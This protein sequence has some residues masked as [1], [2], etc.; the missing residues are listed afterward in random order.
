MTLLRTFAVKKSFLPILLLVF[1][2]G[3][4]NLGG[5]FPG[6]DVINA[7]PTSTEEGFRDVLIIKDISTIPKSP[8]LPEQDILFSF[9]IENRD[10]DKKAENVIVDL[11]DA[12]LFKKKTKDTSGKEIFVLCN[13][14]KCLPDKCAGTVVSGTIPANPA[15]TI[16]PGDQKQINFVLKAPSKNE[17]ANLKSDIDLSF[18][19]RYNFAGS[20]LFKTVVVN[21]VEIKTRQRAG[22]AISLDI[23]EFFGSGP[24]KIDA[25]LKG[26]SYILS[27]YSASITFTIKTVGDPSIGSLLNS[28]IPKSE[29]SKDV[30]K[31]IFP[32]ELMNLHTQN[33]AITDANIKAKLDAP[34]EY[35]T[36]KEDGLSIVCLNDAVK[37]G[38]TYDE[39]TLF[40]GEST[41]LFFRI[42]ET[43]PIKEPFKSFDIRAELNYI[44]ELRSSARIT[45]VPIE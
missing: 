18:S 29:S 41:P 11:L 22:N 31:I 3:C 25:D 33:T 23:P 44:Y 27:P 13:Q 2:A 37:P 32:K 12:P 36:C 20:T 24:M 26:T 40:K 21:L 43:P 39:I 38:N 19:V 6:E 7:N 14:G 4:V 45:V 15:C 8:I 30:L 16:L 5:I 34:T 1:A 10:K 9:V 35:F 17:L 28:K 42:K